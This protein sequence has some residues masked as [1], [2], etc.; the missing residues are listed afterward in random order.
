[1]R[2]GPHRVLQFR[3]RGIGSAACDSVEGGG[4]AVLRGQ[5]LLVVNVAAEVAE[6]LR[7]AGLSATTYVAP[8]PPPVI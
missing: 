5:E 4:H 3:V 2:R 8:E 6:S 1:M 7:V